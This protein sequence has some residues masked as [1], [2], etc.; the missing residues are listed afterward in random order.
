MGNSENAPAV[1]IFPILLAIDSANHSAPSEPAAM[2]SGLLLDVGM[3]NVEMAP[4]VVILPIRLP[5]APVIVNHKL[6]SEPA[7]M[8]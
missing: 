6:L 1:V 7:M 3:L 4:A 8:N 5:P 2:P